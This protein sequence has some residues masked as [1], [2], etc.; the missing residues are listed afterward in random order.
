[1]KKEIK[2]KPAPEIMQELSHELQELLCELAE[3]FECEADRGREVV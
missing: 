3:L 1:M 2:P